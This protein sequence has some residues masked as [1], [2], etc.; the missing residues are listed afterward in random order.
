MGAGLVTL[1]ALQRPGVY[2]RLEN[3]GAALQQGLEAVLRA[4]EI[5][6][7]VN[8]VGSMWT[9]FFGLGAVTDA[10]EARRADRAC[11]ARFFHGMLEQGIYLP[12]SPFE[13]A[14][15]SLAHT[16]DHLARTLRAFESWAD[17]E[18]RG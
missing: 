13:A 5:P 3:A 17:A 14:F 10:D 18:A 11:F 1:Q 8:R 2:E 16:E 15:V 12:P 6:G 4:R 7:V 9:L